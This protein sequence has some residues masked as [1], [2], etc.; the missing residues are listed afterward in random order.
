MGEKKTISR[1][2]ERFYWVGIVKDV[3]ELI[4]SCDECQRTN[5]KMVTAT[6][7][8]HPIPVKNPWF[9]LGIDFIG[10]I[11]PSSAQGNRYILT[12]SDY[13]TKFV[14]AA[15]LPSK[16]AVGVAQ[17]LFKIFMRMGI[18]R[19]LTTDNG[20]EFKN[21]LDDEM[22]KLLGIKR[23]FTT[24][25]HPQ[26]NGLDERFNGT[27]QGML[28]KFIKD[29]RD[30][31][32]ELLDTCVYAYN[33]SVHESTAFS[34]FELMFGRKPILPIDIEVTAKDPEA[35]L[36]EYYNCNEDANAINLKTKHQLET[37]Q[38]AKMN[39]QKAQHKQKEIYDRKHAK[40]NAYVIGEKVLKKDMNKKKRA[41]GK[42]DHRYQGPYVIIK[43]FGKGIYSLQGVSDSSEIINKVSGAHLKPYKDDQFPNVDDY[44]AFSNTCTQSISNES[45]NINVS[46]SSPDDYKTD[47][48]SIPSLPPPISPLREYAEGVVASTPKIYGGFIPEFMPTIDEISPISHMKN[49]TDIPTNNH[50]SVKKH[51]SPKSANDVCHQNH[52]ITQNSLVSKTKKEHDIDYDNFPIKKAAFKKRQRDRNYLKSNAATPIN[53]DCTQSPHNKQIDLPWVLDLH[54]SDENALLKREWLTDTLVNAGQTFIKSFYQKTSG[55]QDVRLGHTLAF[56]VEVGEFVQVLHNGSNHWITISTMGCSQGEV[57]I[58]DSLSPR[59]TSSLEKQIAALLSTKTKQITLRYRRCHKQKGGSDC[60][61]FALAYAD[62]LAA[63]KHPSAIHFDQANLRTHFHSCLKHGVYSPFPTLRVGRENRKNVA[64]EKIVPV[65]C[66]CRLPETF[67]SNMIQC[68]HCLEWFHLETCVETMNEYNKVNKLKWLC[69]KH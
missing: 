44:S 38:T 18:P 24:P 62:I 14:E 10:P 17:V 66:Y 42:L 46:S 19:V 67:S 30:Q 22:A 39:I 5:P 58:F 8:L 2:T 16:H 61:L 12:I 7:E 55:F 34:P 41:G 56:K 1:I 32:D 48:D 64:M 6:P 13:F 52:P 69:K 3:K 51:V 37:L 53:V 45:E 60:G 40:P 65:Y 43:K 28:V 26:A 4:S 9:H 47:F 68:A 23:I 15:A 27:L 50:K 36:E 63:G 35:L 57:D 31:W 54:R 11:Q 21:T 25:Y 59:V 20:K 49:Q 33:T 29:K